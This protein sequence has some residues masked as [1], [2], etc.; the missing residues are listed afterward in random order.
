MKN[1]G[2]GVQSDA[3]KKPARLPK[4]PLANPLHGKGKMRSGKVAKEKI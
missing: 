3:D 4:K 2:L 1:K